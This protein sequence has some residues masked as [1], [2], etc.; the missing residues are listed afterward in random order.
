MKFNNLNPP[1]QGITHHYGF[2]LVSVVYEAYGTI[3][4]I[5]IIGHL[6]CTPFLGRKMKYLHTHPKLVFF[7]GEVGDNM[8]QKPN[9][10]IGGFFFN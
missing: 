10:N 1:T 4:Y 2:L 9:G 7:V 6:Y 8:L 5:Q 3:P